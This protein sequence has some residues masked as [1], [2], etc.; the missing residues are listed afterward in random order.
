[1]A[2]YWVL[3]GTVLGLVLIWT[4]DRRK[5]PTQPGKVSIYSKEELGMAKFGYTFNV[6]APATPADV[7]K[8]EF[9]FTVAGVVQPREVAVAN[10]GDLISKEFV[11]EDAGEPEISVVLIDSDAKGNASA[12]S[13]PFTFKVTDDIGPAQPGEIGIASKRQI[14]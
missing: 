12:P 6:P 9:E 10:V 3:A 8:R 14:D 5:R 4:W 13:K 7:A 2:I 1:M 11:F